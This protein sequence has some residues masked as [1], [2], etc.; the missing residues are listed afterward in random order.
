M[1]A[2]TTTGAGP[3]SS[4]R[5]RLDGRVAVVTGAAQGL[6]AAI[7]RSLFEEGAVVAAVDLDEARAGD[8]VAELGD[9]ERAIALAADVRDR[10]ALARA[11][12]EVVT[13]FG[14]LDVMVNNAALNEA[15]P[16]DRVEEAEW[17]D[18]MAVNLRGV[19]FGCQLAAE[20]MRPN[21]F[22]RIIN[23]GSDAGQQPNRFVGAHYAAAKGGV[24]ALTKAVAQTVA[25]DGITVN[26][27]APAAFE[28]PVM[29][30][31]PREQIEMLRADIP[32]GRF[33]RPEEVGAAAVFLAGDSAGYITG[34]TLD[35]NGGKF[36]R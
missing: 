22:G 20:R 23:L 26:A 15:Q 16:F 2:I 25:A 9:P 24:I 29:S 28:G 21:G 12:E 6:G 17:D 19:L 4:H 5:F 33:G 1:S 36:M 18:L 8:R 30:T 31:L 32:V 11:L 14:R 10:A 34:A 3:G 13:R 7:A 27:I 35:V